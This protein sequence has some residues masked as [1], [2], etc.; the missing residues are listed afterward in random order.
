MKHLANL[1]RLR[2]LILYGTRLGDAGLF[3]LRGLKSLVV[4]DIHQTRVTNA[5][6]AHLKELANLEYL[7]T[8]GC[9][10]A[11][12]GALQLAGLKRLRVLRT[13]P[14]TEKTKDRLRAAIPGL[15]FEGVH[16]WNYVEEAKREKK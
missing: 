6:L 8:T 14:L 15:N 3:H 4:L 1:Q 13:E 11:D 16:S 9:D 2:R 12:A 10:V 5:G 7:D